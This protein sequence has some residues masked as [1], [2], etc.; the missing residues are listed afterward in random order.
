[1]ADTSIPTLSFKNDLTY[2]VVVYDS[3]DN[4]DSDDDAQSNYFGTLTSL[5]TVGANATVAIQPIHRSSAFIVE[6]AVDKK[7]VKRCTKLG[8]NKTLTSFEIAKADEDAMTA[9]FQFIDFYLKN[10]DDPTSKAFT[11]LLNGDNTYGDM[12]TFFQQYPA[13]AACTFQT[14]MMATT[15]I[16]ITP[17]SVPKPPAEATYS[18]SKLA[19]LMG[20][21]WPDGLPD[22]EVANFKVSDKNSVLDISG[23]IDISTLP[24]ETPQI[25]QNVSTVLGD[26]KVL[27]FS[28]VF[29]H[30]FSAS[31][32][33]VLSVF[34]TRLSLS[35]DTIAIPAGGNNSL[36]VTKPA[37]TVDINPTFKFVQF[38]LSGVIPFDINGKQFDADISLSVDN[39][40]ASVGVVIE[41]DNSSFPPP[42]G[43]KGLFFD[44]FGVGIG[45]FFEPPSCIVGVQGKFH[46]G[47]NSGNVISL[48]DDTFALICKITGEAVTP[49][50]A[51]FYIPTLDLNTVVTLF[52]NKSISLDVPVTFEDLSFKWTD[53]LM[54]AYI[55][56]DGTL[57]PSGYGFSAICNVGPFGFYGDAE[58]NLNNGLT[59]DIEVSPVN[60]NNVFQLT[61]DGKG[62]SIK[63]D[64]AGNP[65]KNNFVPTT[66]AEKDAVAN[67]AT[68]QIVSAGGPNLII[69]TFNSPILHLNAKA[70]LFE[71]VEYAV[72]A[73]VNK[74]GIKFEL[75][76]GAILTQKMVCNL[77][78]FHNLYGE[79]GYYIDHSISLPVI[80]GESLGSLPLKADAAL[81]LSI[82]TSTSDVVISAG[83][84]FDFEGCH[85]T[86]GDFNADINIAKI[87]DFVAAI[88]QYIEDNAKAIFNQLLDTAEHWAA[89]A[90][91]GIVTGFEDAGKVMKNAYGKTKEEMV[92]LLKDA[93]F[94][95][96][97]IANSLKNAYGAASQDV[98]ALLKAAGFDAATVGGAIK[99]AWNCGVDD[100]SWAMQQVGYAA[101]DVATG[102]ENAFGSGVQDITNTFRKWGFD[103]VDVARVIINPPFN[104]DS[105][106]VANIMKQAGYVVDD[107]AAG[108]KGAW[109]CT[110]ND[111]TYA[112]K[113]AG[114]AA[115]EVAASLINVFH[116]ASQ[117]VAT[118]LKTMGYTAEEVG[119]AIKN[120]WNC[121]QQDVAWA[122]MMAGYA[123]SDISQSLQAAFGATAQD[124]AN[125]FKAVG[126]AAQ[127]VANT[128][129]NDFH[130]TI[131]EAATIMNQAGYAAEDVASSLKTA[132]NTSVDAVADAM[133]QAGYA[134][135]D[136]KNAFEDLG[137]DFKNLADTAWSDAKHDLNPS[138]WF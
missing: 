83:G 64:A 58:L 98:A 93:G 14:Y 52:T 51:S 63:I 134:A 125:A 108:I 133:K 2:D 69:N 137:G 129:A 136:V 117:D 109:N 47:Q 71:L 61:G 19:Q 112:L 35:F 29:N 23:D 48:D 130:K 97:D 30:A 6:S 25:A 95:A 75:D 55:L 72:A 126:I 119:S 41:G 135:D 102:L 15:Y 20:A 68:K 26:K 90:A 103:I 53:G 80:G 110:A 1:M 76:Y 16:A 78:D 39:E 96:N 100:V 60:W 18:L 57:A 107:I 54:A 127:D 99:N 12:N 11:T 122:M 86:F 49:A 62:Y 104:G 132:F 27:T 91:K 77:T 116:S 81:H 114:Y 105:I 59:A 42:P 87:A 82:K 88:V 5:G 111:V 22:I 45:V 92:T 120:A 89:A 4:E 67:A 84:Q 21:K 128:L 106:A 7:P 8:T 124:V 34:G 123:A 9:T 131:D 36:A 46:V 38:T 31:I 43:L 65:I 66:Q 10:P 70:S 24:F 118:A 50:F 74:D 73:D 37:V 94:V 85:F 56:P 40:E 17:V 33:G 113:A 121:G 138:N 79:F 13:Y 101:A 32:S 3:F 28:L 115:D 44:Q